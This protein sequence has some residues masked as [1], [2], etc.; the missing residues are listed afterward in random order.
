MTCEHC[1][2]NKLCVPENKNG[3]TDYVDGRRYV[4]FSFMPGDKAYA[5]LGHTVYPANIKR[6]TNTAFNE[7]PIGGIHELVSYE[8]NV[9]DSR[10]LR[11]WFTDNED[12]IDRLFRNIDDA[13]AFSKKGE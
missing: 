7:D 12:D 4:R 10:V 6:V 8:I 5:V 2:Y 1:L 3:C 13:I 9:C 11:M